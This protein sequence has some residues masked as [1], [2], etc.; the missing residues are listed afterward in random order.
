[1]SFKLLVRHQHA[2]FSAKIGI[3]FVISNFSCNFGKDVWIKGAGACKKS[4]AESWRYDIFC[5][6]LQSQIDEPT[7][8][9]T[10]YFS[11]A[12]ITHESKIDTPLTPDNT[13]N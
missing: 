1:M 7:I 12:Y 10:P 8:H 9:F 2:Y 3:F 5:V 13:H 11:N 4:L 6:C